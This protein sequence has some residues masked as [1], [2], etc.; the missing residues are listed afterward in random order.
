MPIFI[1]NFTRVGSQS[2]DP[3]LRQAV[4]TLPGVILEPLWYNLRATKLTTEVRKLDNN[5]TCPNCK[6]P[7]KLFLNPIISNKGLISISSAIL[8]ILASSF[9]EKD[10]L[11][12]RAIMNKRIPNFS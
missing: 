2:D 9:F 12:L 3:D 10:F 6:Q 4:A 1:F 5:L 8:R 7:T 11:L